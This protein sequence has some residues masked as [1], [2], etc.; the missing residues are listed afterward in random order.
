MLFSCTE[1]QEMFRDTNVRL[2]RSSRISHWVIGTASPG[3]SQKASSLG[4]L[5]MTAES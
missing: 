2:L 5:F 4:H 3:C 1:A